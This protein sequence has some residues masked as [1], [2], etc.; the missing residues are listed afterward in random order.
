[1]KITFGKKPR[2]YYYGALGGGDVFLYDDDY[3]LVTDDYRAI[4]LIDGVPFNFDAKDQVIL[5]DCE[6]VIKD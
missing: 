4:R 3:F 6:L 2:Y 1:M 5:V